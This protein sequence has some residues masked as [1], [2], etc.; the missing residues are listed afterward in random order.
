IDTWDEM[1]VDMLGA[2]TT[3]DTE[4]GR[5]MIEFTTRYRDRRIQART[6][7]LMEAEARMSREA[8]G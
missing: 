5:R 4:L 8:C 7:S 6:A 2:P 3:D 1:S